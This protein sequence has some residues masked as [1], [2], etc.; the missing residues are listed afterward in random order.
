MAQIPTEDQRKGMHALMVSTVA[1][2]DRKIPGA[3]CSFCR[4]SAVQM[5]TLDFACT[6]GNHASADAA[7]T[8]TDYKDA[9]LGYDATHRERAR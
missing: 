2:K 6:K 8:C 3:S 1:H 5:G 9:R 7:K 4:F